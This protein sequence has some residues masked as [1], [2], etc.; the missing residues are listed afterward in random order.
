M[1]LRCRVPATN[2]AQIKPTQ[3]SARLRSLT[4]MAAKSCLSNGAWRRPNVGNSSTKGKL[5]RYAFK[6]YSYVASYRA[7]CSPALLH[8]DCTHTF[9]NPSHF[10]QSKN[11]ICQCPCGRSGSGRSCRPSRPS[12]RRSSLRSTSVTAVASALPTT[13]RRPDIA[14]KMSLPAL[15]KAP[16]ITVT[17]TLPTKASALVE[18]GV[19]SKVT[20]QKAQQNSKP[21]KT[22]TETTTICQ[23]RPS[24][25]I[26]TSGGSIMVSTLTV[27]YCQPTTTVETSGADRKAQPLIQNFW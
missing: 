12:N 25:F 22:V 1:F 6:P 26:N 19:N 21:P 14:T 27:N 8:T 4:E 23:D 11:E 5:L 7:F 16:A 2:Y 9:A 18:R 15:P 20:T 24:T 3:W 10:D 13:V 17:T